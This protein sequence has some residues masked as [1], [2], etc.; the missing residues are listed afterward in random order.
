[1]TIQ[2]FNTQYFLNMGNIEKVDR[3]CSKYT[4]I[5]SYKTTEYSPCL[6]EFSH[7]NEVYPFENLWRLMR[8]HAS[9]LKVV[10]DK[11]D[12]DDQGGAGP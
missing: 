6:L 8:K 3:F 11:H 5:C 1:M 2:F 12:D 9:L 4:Q 10:S 7:H